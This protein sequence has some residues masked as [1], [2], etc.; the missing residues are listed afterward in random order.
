MARAQ[1]RALPC[2]Y[3][4]PAAMYSLAMSNASRGL[5]GFLRKEPDSYWQVWLI[6]API[7]AM[8]PLVFLAAAGK[9]LYGL[10]GAVIA[11]ISCGIGQSYRL[12]RRRNS[13]PVAAARPFARPPLNAR[14]QAR[15]RTDEPWRR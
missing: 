2:C 1:E 3:I 8:I 14:Q 10:M 6:Y 11:L 4:I 15:A 7:S 12:D 13:G 9:W 5:W